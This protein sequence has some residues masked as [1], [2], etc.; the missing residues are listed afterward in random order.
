MSAVADLFHRLLSKDYGKLVLETSFFITAAFTSAILLNPRRLR[1]FR[2]VLLRRNLQRSKRKKNNKIN[3]GAIFGMD[4]GGTLTKIVYFQQRRPDEF[5]PPPIVKPPNLPSNC[6]PPISTLPPA[7]SRPED[8]NI[9]K[10]PTPSLA[11]RGSSDSLAQLDLPDHQ[12]ALQEL[13]NYMDSTT[14][15]SSNTAVIRDDNLSIYSSFLEG[16]LHFLHFETRNM[17]AAINYVSASAFTEHI[18]S[19]GCTGGG[20]HKYSNEIFEKLEITVNKYDELGCL[21]R[22]MLFALMNFP[23]ECYTYRN[24]ETINTT[25]AVDNQGELNRSK[26]FDK[27]KI[28]TPEKVPPPASRDSRA[29]SVDKQDSSAKKSKWQKDD[30]EHTK[31][32]ILPISHRSIFP[33]LVVNIG[34]GVSILKVT[35]P[36]QFQRVSGT[37]LGGGTYWG[38]CRL[39]TKCQTYEEVLDLAENGDAGVVDMLVRDIY[40]GDYSGLLSGTMVASSF[41]KLVMKENPLEGVNEEDLALALLMMI[42][43]NIGQVAYLNAQLHNCNKIFFVGSFLRHNSISCRRLAFAIDFWSKGSMEALF[44]H[45]EGYFGALGTFLQS[46][47]GDDVDKILLNEYET[48]NTSL[49]PFN[50]SNVGGSGSNGSD[51]ES[52]SSGKN[53]VSES[54]VK[55]NDSEEKKINRSLD[56][57]DALLEKNGPA[58]SSVPKVNLPQSSRRGRSVSDDVTHRSAFGSNSN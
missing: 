25:N 7:Q 24:K 36:G 21:V 14:N 3:I 11:K 26:S 13:Y 10:S 27:M 42:T 9:P 32:V 55:A 53:A 8:E 35:G 20:A 44:S 54:S 39:L 49:T 50:N 5:T 56:Q 57:Y 41:G 51:R 18:Q 40:G 37:S 38:L 19:I 23:E 15:P 16:K 2:N 4:V 1:L 43:N 29:N 34:S 31:K 6:I 30:K 28:A 45:H 47:F 17:L 22:G 46:A 12:A 48:Q 58:T 33:Y 52:T